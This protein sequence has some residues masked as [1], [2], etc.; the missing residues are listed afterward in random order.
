MKAISTILIALGLLLGL[1]WEGNERH[2]AQAAG[3]TPDLAISIDTNGGGDDCD[4]RAST[5]GIGTTCTV[6]IGD[7]LTVKGHID[8]YTGI[9]GTGGYGGVRMQFSY[10]QG[11][12]LK[13]R[14]TTTEMGPAGT[15]FWPECSSRSEVW[16]NGEYFPWAYIAECHT[17]GPAS[18]YLGKFVEA[19]F[20]CQTPG[21]WYVTLADSNSY[22]YNSAHTPF[23]ADKEGDEVLTI[24]CVTSA[25]GGVTELAVG[26]G[27][28]SAKGEDGTH[29]ARG[30]VLATAAVALLCA[31]GG[32]AWFAR[33]VAG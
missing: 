10:T 6:S 19:D 11:L 1:S 3:S 4:T 15:P 33:R 16:N 25:I 13:P 8:G 23:T 29:S 7:Y 21:S 24:N 27:L 26:D 31:L 14:T 5:A 12:E 22:L 9:S 32:G 28:A 17:A 18:T 2:P 30:A 20:K